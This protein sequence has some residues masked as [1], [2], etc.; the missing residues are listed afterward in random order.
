MVYEAMQRRAAR[1]LTDSATQTDMDPQDAKK[2][3]IYAANEL[4]TTD[5]SRIPQSVNRSPW[6]RPRSS[7]ISWII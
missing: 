5:D 7:S 2:K 6:S 4:I 1:S 3:K